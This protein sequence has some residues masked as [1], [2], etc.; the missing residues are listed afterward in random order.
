MRPFP[1]LMDLNTKQVYPLNDLPAFIVGRS[2]DA[3]LPVADVNCSR[4]QF[5]IVRESAGHFIGPLSTTTPTL[6]NGKAVQG[7]IGVGH[8]ALI[9]AGNSR[10]RFLEREEKV[11]VRAAAAAL[12][13]EATQASPAGV[14]FQPSVLA[15]T[16]MAGNNSASLAGAQLSGLIPLSGT[17]MI[18]RDAKRNQLVL[19]HAH[20]SRYHAQVVV[21]GSKALITDLSSANGTFVNGTRIQTATPIKPG[22]RVDIGPF[23]LV[24]TGA[25]LLPQSRE[26]NVELTCKGLRKIVPD[27]TTGKMLALLD[28]ISLV[29]RP[30][31]FV[32]ILGPSGSGKS[33]LMAALS[34]RAPANE[35]CVLL[36]QRDLY[37]NFESLKQDMVVVAQRD[38]LHERLRVVTALR[39]TAKLRLPPDTS[40]GEIETAIQ[41]MLATVGLTT[42]RGTP[43][44]F[45]SGGQVKRVSLASEIISKPTLLF[46]D[47]VTSG[48]DEQTDRE[49]MGLF[50]DLAD[51]G[52]TV[53]C[54][55]HSL[56]NVE[57][58][59]HLV[60]IL[61]SGGRL[62]F[63]GKPAEALSYFRID[64]LGDVYEKLKEKAADEWHSAFLA[65]TFFKQYV[66]GRMAAEQGTHQ[67]SVYRPSRGI[68]EWL[69]MSVRQATLLARRYGS[70]AVSDGPAL[71]AML[72]QSLAIA[73][74]LTM[75]FGRVSNIEVPAEQLQR[76][77]NLYFLMA[78]ASIWFSCNNSVKEIVKERV[79]FSR[80]RAFNLLTGSYYV[81]KTLILIP[82]S[83]A[84]AC[85]ITFLVHMFCDPP[86]DR[87][88]VYLVLSMTAAVRVTL[89][90]L[91]S[92]VSTSEDM[93]VTL[94]PIALIPQIALAGVVAPLEGVA[95]LLAQVGVTAYWA[96]NGLQAGLPESLLMLG[97]IQ[98]S[99]VTEA[100][101]ILACHGIAFGATT[102]V[103]LNLQGRAERR[104]A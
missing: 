101:V 39:Y 56:A 8:G 49:M 29:I 72:A 70:L 61:A 30:H 88:L 9:Q 98:K 57:R 62:A 90:L 59:C 65:S 80:E 84:Q 16:V 33:T 14:P 26:N 50:R 93:A 42:Q 34:A 79:I 21:Q 4:R 24:F 64:R 20:V 83:V 46:V 7:R 60:V 99:S 77:V 32:C 91:L 11:D 17:M 3:N 38:A 2:Q 54:I 28:D 40:S 35:G 25:G 1:A 74:L 36:N 15:P 104:R 102:L 31:E 86:G 92:A 67:I 58:S 76:T 19:P 89:G 78:V 63:V 18:G 81:S 103:V 69:R 96:N 51:K 87:A 66:G 47:E 94:V 52:K 82:I 73:V 12:A 100:M 71:L 48:L 6:C 13:R 41:E 68:R 95:K 5:R 27:R 45:L 53:V 55:T 97:I 75:V 37:G 23:S 10:F 43:I 22:D 85:L 44:R